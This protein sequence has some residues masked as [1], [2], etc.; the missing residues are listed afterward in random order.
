MHLSKLSGWDLHVHPLTHQLRDTG[1]KGGVEGKPKEQSPRSALS[2]G[3]D[4]K[5]V[6]KAELLGVDSLERCVI[7]LAT[8]MMHLTKTAYRKGLGFIFDQGFQRIWSV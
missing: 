6:L 2:I 4:L 7:S 5:I 1:R 8:T 3:R